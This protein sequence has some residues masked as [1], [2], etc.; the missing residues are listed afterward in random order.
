MKSEYGLS[1]YGR[2]IV[3]AE[4]GSPPPVRTAFVMVTLL[5][6]AWVLIPVNRAVISALLQ[7]NHVAAG[8]RKSM[9][10]LVAAGWTSRQV[11]ATDRLVGRLVTAFA[12]VLVFYNIHQAIHI[13]H[14]ADNI[15]RPVEYKEPKW[16]YDQYLISTMEITFAFNVPVSICGTSLASSL[17]LVLLRLID[18]I[19]EP[20]SDQAPGK[21]DETSSAIDGGLERLVSSGEGTEDIIHFHFSGKPSLLKVD[22]SFRAALPDQG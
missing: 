5:L 9:V 3:V 19:G 2:P 11:D 10:A 7:R 17:A 22:Q 1:S 20:T 16:L 15:A 14:F 12:F 13:A 4:V 18:A 6:G 8:S 21:T